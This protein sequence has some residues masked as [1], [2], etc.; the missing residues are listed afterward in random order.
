MF[1]K[2]TKDV[3]VVGAGPVGMF[4]A[5]VLSDRGVSVDIFDSRWQTSAHSYALALHP[6]T[7]ANFEKVGLLEEVLR[8][9]NRVRK[10]RLYEGPE[11]RQ[12]VSIS[13][14]EDDFSFVAIMRQDILEDTLERA[15]RKAG[16]KVRWNHQISDINPEPYHNEVTIEVL[17]KESFGYAIAHSEWLVEKVKREKA[18]FVVGADGHHSI[19]RKAMG[20]SFDEVRKP[21]Y[22]AVFEFKT[23]RESGESVRIVLNENTTDVCWPMPDG[24][25]RWSFQLDGDLEEIP[26]RE[27]DQF[28]LSVDDLGYPELEDGKLEQL[29]RVRAPWFDAPVGEI[30][31][32]KLVRFDHRIASDFG[33]GTVLIAG[34][35]CHMTAPAGIQSM[36]VGLREARDVADVIAQ[37]RDTLAYQTA[38]DAYRDARRREWNFLLGIEG[39]LELRDDAHAWLKPYKDRL[40]SAI[41][42]SGRDLEM[43]AGQLGLAAISTME[44]V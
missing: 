3:V 43:I 40:I 13:S 25:Y 23:D 2:K 33:S 8:H 14:L 39:G 7:L 16:V 20:Y 12:E 1:S 5:L 38:L 37:R 29:I 22:Y 24:Y 36:N 10:M 19:I 35:A 28:D 32:R 31:W 41:P 6:D 30:S 17:G 11:F 15:L 26:P 21:V 34:D 18:A 44:A 27:K 4:A 9:A 42:A